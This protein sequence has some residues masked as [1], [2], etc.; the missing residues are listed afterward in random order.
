MKRTE[1]VLMGVGGVGREAMK[2]FA[3]E[4]RPAAAAIDGVNLELMAI[5]DKSGVVHFNQGGASV[6]QIHS[7]L[8]AKEKGE[9]LDGIPVEN[10]KILNGGHKCIVADLTGSLYTTPLLIQAVKTGCGIVS[11]NKPPFAGPYEDWKALAHYSRCRYNTTLGGPRGIPYELKTLRRG[12][13]KIKKIEMA[14]SGSVNFSLYDMARAGSLGDHPM[15][16]RTMAEA[17]RRGLPESDPRKDFDGGDFRNK[18]IIGGREAF[19]DDC[20]WAQNGD[21][22]IHPLLPP[23]VLGSS[24]EEF[25]SE[26][27]GKVHKYFRELV[28]RHEGD[29]EPVLRKHPVYMATLTPEKAT[30]DLHYFDFHHPIVRNLFEEHIVVAAYLEGRT[31]PEIFKGA[32]AGAKA[33]AMRVWAD[34]IEVAQMMS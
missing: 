12:G 18:S 4:H 3:D 2:C 32:G 24:P 31:D 23:E 9:R 19:G 11:A 7:L 13:A 25:Q 5:A 16:D 22:E 33:T 10:L 8:N 27:G 15:F 21:V 26:W 1:V 34:I 30:V 6:Q 29:R 14:V 20:L 17:I 28:F